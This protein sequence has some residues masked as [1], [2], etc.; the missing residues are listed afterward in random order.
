MNILSDH[1][2]VQQHEVLASKSK[3]RSSVSPSVDQ[4][5]GGNSPARK[6]LLFAARLPG[7]T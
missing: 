7:K 6:S 1:S 5:N 4:L 2:S 3:L